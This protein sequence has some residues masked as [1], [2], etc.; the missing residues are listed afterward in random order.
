MIPINAILFFALL[1]FF[2]CSQQGIISNHSLKEE[3]KSPRR[4]TI[5]QPTFYNNTTYIKIKSDP[6]FSPIVFISLHNDE[7]TGQ[8]VVSNYLKQNHSAFIQ[9]ENNKL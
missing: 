6:A 5:I 8:Q 2:S 7:A 3:I 9:I 1:N 4:D